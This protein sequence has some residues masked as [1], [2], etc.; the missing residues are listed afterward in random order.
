MK[1]EA[2]LGGIMGLRV[3]EKRETWRKVAVMQAVVAWPVWARDQ[4]D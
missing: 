2:G 1:G 3:M 4:T